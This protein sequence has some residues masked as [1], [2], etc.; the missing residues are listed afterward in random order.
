MAASPRRREREDALAPRVRRRLFRCVSASAF[1]QCSR[2]ARSPRS[3]TVLTVAA[4]AVRSRAVRLL[5][6]ATER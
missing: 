5:Y 3:R 6:L 1:Q 4:N 2:A